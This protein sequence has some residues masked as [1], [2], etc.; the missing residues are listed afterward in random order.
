MGIWGQARERLTLEPIFG[1]RTFGADTTCGDIHH[2]P[3]PDGHRVC[4]M[5]CFATG[6]PGHPD[7]KEDAAGRLR[8]KNWEPEGGKDRWGRTVEATSYSKPRAEAKDAPSTR[9]DRRA[10]IYGRRSVRAESMDPDRLNAA[11]DRHSAT[12]MA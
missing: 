2:G 4:C 3:I 10:E 6:V 5:V 1:P 8:L 12:V 9:K 7:L 11:I